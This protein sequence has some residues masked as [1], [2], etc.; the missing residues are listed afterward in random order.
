M[1]GQT[2]FSTFVAQLGEHNRQIGRYF[3]IPAALSNAARALGKTLY[4][5]EAIRDTYY[6]NKNRK[7]EPSIDDQMSDASFAVIDAM[8]AEPNYS[9]EL[10]SQR[11]SDSADQDLFNYTK[12]DK[13]ISFIIAH[14]E[15][16]H[17]V[18]VSTWLIPWHTGFLAPQC[19][20]M[21]LALAYDETNDIILVHDSAV[22]QIGL[23][24]RSSPRLV[25]SKLV[26]DIG[27]RGRITHTDYCCSA[28]SFK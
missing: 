2:I 24:P 13:A 6:K 7:P 10:T 12:A 20:H 16:E 8:E 17:P 18:I 14:L 25:G 27:L 23:V 4:T 22:N 5:Q 15:Q 19:C 9:K 21:W 28:T 1:K 3:C 26:V 11:Y